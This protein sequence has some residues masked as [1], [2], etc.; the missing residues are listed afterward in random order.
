MMTRFCQSTEAEAAAS[1]GVAV[2]RAQTSI[3]KVLRRETMVIEIL[4]C[5]TGNA[6]LLA[7]RSLFNG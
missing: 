7:G 1:A 2:A 5:E 4:P 3:V 6:A